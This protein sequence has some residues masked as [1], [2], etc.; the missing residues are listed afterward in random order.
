MSGLP[1]HTIT[2]RPADL[3]YAVYAVRTFHVTP[4]T[5]TPGKLLGTA[6]TLDDARRLVPP[7]L[8]CVERHPDDDSAIVESWL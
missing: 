4:G 2:H 6:D 1:I 8:V 5:V 3:P 7:G